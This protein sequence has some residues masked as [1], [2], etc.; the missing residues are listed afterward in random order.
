MTA[1]PRE[2]IYHFTMSTKVLHHGVGAKCHV[3]T[4]F[5]HPSKLVRDKYP[6]IDKGHRT[7]V[8]LVGIETKLVNRK[9]QQCYTFRSEDFPN[10]VL[11]AVKRYVVVVEEGP[12]ESFF[13]SSSESPGTPQTPRVSN[14]DAALPSRSGVLAEEIESFRAA[15]AIIDD[16]NE[17]AE[18]ND[19]WVDAEKQTRELTFKYTEVFNNHYKYRHIIDDHNANRMQPIALEK[20]WKTSWWPD[21]VFAFFLGSTI[22]NAQRGYEHFGKNPTEEV[23]Q[24]RRRLAKELIFNPWVPNSA[25]ILQEEPDRAAK[26]ARVLGCKLVTIPKYFE[27]RGTELVASRSTYNQRVCSCRAARTR[28]YCRCTPGT[29]LCV[30]CYARHCV[31][32]ST[33]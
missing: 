18:E 15:G 8:V 26:R 2:V 14:D 10:A 27:F 25:D 16:D 22:V 28:T 29:Y 1:Y 20:T 31:S 32:L 4:R 30:E 23:L 33:A 12:T 9:D 5:L 24:F 13:Q 7:T 19:P 21:R 3:L 6:N 17:P 11:H